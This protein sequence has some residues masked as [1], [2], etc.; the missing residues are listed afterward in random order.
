VTTPELDDFVHAMRPFVSYA[1]SM[2]LS[3][4]MAHVWQ[5]TP[6]VVSR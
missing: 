1:H 5:R 3:A 6:L 4:T 2:Q